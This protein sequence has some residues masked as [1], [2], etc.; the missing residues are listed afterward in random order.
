MYVLDVSTSSRAPLTNSN[1]LQLV[2]ANC[3]VQC[4]TK[5]DGVW[6]TTVEK[7]NAGAL[8][9]C[10]GSAVFPLDTKQQLSECRRI[11][12]QAFPGPQA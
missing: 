6:T 11:R 2:A 7:A 1:G 9:R 5:S 3:F 12:S 10:V 4:Q 8:D